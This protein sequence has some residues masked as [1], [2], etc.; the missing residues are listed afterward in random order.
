MASLLSSFAWFETP[1]KLY[2][3]ARSRARRAKPSSQLPVCVLPAFMRAA[4]GYA[5]MSPTISPAEIAAC[6]Y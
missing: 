3:A 5:F 2:R 6:S 1:N 4:R